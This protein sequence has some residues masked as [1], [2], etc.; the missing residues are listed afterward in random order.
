MIIFTL[1]II[2]GIVF[3][4][5]NLAAFT[6]TV[7]VKLDLYAFSVQSPGVAVW[8]IILFCYFLGVFTACL[9]GIYEIFKQRQT[10]RQL[11]HNL[12]I[13]SQELKRAGGAETAVASGDPTVSPK[14]G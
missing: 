12:E 2:I 8:V 1:I 5:E 10:V 4:I 7:Q 13:L 3:I 14:T 11:R 6:H 9:Y